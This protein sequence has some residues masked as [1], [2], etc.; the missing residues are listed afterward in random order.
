MQDSSANLGRE[1]GL[2]LL[3]KPF[4]SLTTPNPQETTAEIEHKIDMNRQQLGVTV[5]KT[6]FGN[7]FVLCVEALE[8]GIHP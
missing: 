2:N 1:H 4:D 5:P 6:E 3:P 7:R 8:G